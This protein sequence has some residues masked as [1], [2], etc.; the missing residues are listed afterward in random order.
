MSVIFD[1]KES[2]KRHIHLVCVGH[3][4]HGKSSILGRLFFDTNNVGKDT[5]EKIK[6][7]AEE[8][9]KQGFEYA[10]VMD[11]IKEER[12]R[13][14]T[15]GLAHKK[16][17]TDKNSFTFADAPGHKD[18]IRNMLVG[19]SEAEGAVLVIAAD[20]GIQSQTEEH[21]YLCKMLGV[22]RIIIALNKMDKV[23]YSEEEFKKLEESITS[24]IKRIGYDP[25]EVP[26]I[27]VSAIEGENITSK[28]EKMGWF[29]GPVFFELLE[30]LP[31]KKVPVDL[32][33][34]LPVQDVWE[35]DGKQVVIGRIDSGKIKPGDSIVVMPQDKEYKV[36]KMFRQDE[37]LQ[38]ARPGD[39]LYL[40]L[41]G[42]EKGA[43]QRG[44]ILGVPESKPVITDTFQAQVMLLKSPKPIRK[45]HKSLFMMSTEETPCVVEELI[46]RI[47]TVTG[48]AFDNPEEVKEGESA[49]VRV[50]TEKPVFI[51]AQS[52]IPQL[53]SF[54]FEEDHQNVA[55][56]VC[57]KVE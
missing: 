47:D 38:E 56:G 31:E 13:G 22:P 1:G 21:L 17:Q 32:P 49:I 24:L 9:G 45:G 40:Y 6:I 36:E 15:I 51:E 11:Q 53:S 26:I 4:D 54:R 12:M 25:Q 50:K 8:M 28:P 14:I 19:A 18:F 48:D 35:I 10:F 30:N 52:V 7:M 2:D 3:R 5:M 57:Y 42:L 55:M 37:E 29:T 41:E 16:L 46:Q 33:L 39:N 20:E 27:P 44:N 34:R 23:N 43:I